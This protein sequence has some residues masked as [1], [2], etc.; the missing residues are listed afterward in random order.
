MTFNSDPQKLFQYH[1]QLNCPHCGHN[2]LVQRGD[3]YICL[4][5]DFRRTLSEAKESNSILVV[6]TLFALVLAIAMA[7][8]E[9]D[10]SRQLSPNSLPTDNLLPN[11]FPSN[12]GERSFYP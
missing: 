9:R 6:L 5:C 8:Y 7:G 10:P 1:A 12:D 4:N 3:T 2:A 11:N